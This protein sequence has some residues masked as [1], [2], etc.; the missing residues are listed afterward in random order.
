[1]SRGYENDSKCRAICQND[2]FVGTLFLSLSLGNAINHQLLKFFPLKIKQGS[3][4]LRL[5]DLDVWVVWVC[6]GFVLV[7]HLVFPRVCVVVICFKT[8]NIEEKKVD[9]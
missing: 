1:M 5:L 3:F 8:N 9:F 4:V 6:F 2:R 7:R